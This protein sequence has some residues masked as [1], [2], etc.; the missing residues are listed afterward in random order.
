MAIAATNH[1][2]RFFDR[3]WQSGEGEG[4]FLLEPIP[5]IV[6]IETDKAQ[7]A[8]TYKA[9]ASAIRVEVDHNNN[10]SYTT[11]KPIRLLERGLFDSRTGRC[12][13]GPLP[14]L[15]DARRALAGGGL[16]RNPDLCPDGDHHR[17]AI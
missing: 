15:E 9:Q 8:N 14:E 12:L 11:A 17:R 3:E 2:Q 6:G 10:N 5:P 16:C 1:L 7:N 13:P 4:T